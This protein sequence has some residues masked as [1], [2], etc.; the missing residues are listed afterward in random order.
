[1]KPTAVIINT[2]RGA[3]IDEPALYQALVEGSISG[4]GLDVCEP[5]PPSPNNPL[6]QL[7]QVLVSGH[8]AFFSESSMLELQ[9][10]ATEAVIVALRGD[11]PPV[12]VNPQVKEQENRRIGR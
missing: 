10:K 8:S 2:A 6:F 9:Q 4:A 7:E 11:W 5:E 12:L 3:I 1:M